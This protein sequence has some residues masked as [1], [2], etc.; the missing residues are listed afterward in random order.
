[1]HEL[2]DKACV[3]YKYR[4]IKKMNKLVKKVCNVSE[5]N[6]PYRLSG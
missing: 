4:I 3:C 2:I 1:M 6:W 5:L